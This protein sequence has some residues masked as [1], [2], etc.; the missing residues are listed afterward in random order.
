M[1]AVELTWFFDHSTLGRVRAT[2]FFTPGCAPSR[3]DD[4]YP[5]EYA[6]TRFYIERQAEED[7]TDSIEAEI[8]DH[9]ERAGTSPLYDAI[10]TAATIEYN[11][12]LAAAE[13]AMVASYAH[14]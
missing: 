8:D 12:Q 10:V 13:W 3:E 5:P 1:P 2:G 9:I 14:Y 4:G 7:V 6:D 11:D